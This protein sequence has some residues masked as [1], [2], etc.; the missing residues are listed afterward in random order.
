[1]REARLRAGLTQRQLAAAAGLSQASIARIESGKTEPTFAQVD[2]L[3][4]LC[5]LELRVGLVPG[6]G[7]AWSVARQNLRL[8]PE[9]RVRQHQAALRFARAGREALAR[10]RA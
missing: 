3:V 6:E 1:M 4:S 10:A 8:R 5:G 9:A 7:S 2:R